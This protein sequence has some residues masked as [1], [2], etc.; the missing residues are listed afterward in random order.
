MET[1]IE[2]EVM[3]E[4]I[5]KYYQLS[6]AES[7]VVRGLVNE[8]LRGN[9]TVPLSEALETAAVVAQEL[10]REMRKAFYEFKLRETAHAVC[11]RGNL[12]ATEALP[13]TPSRHRDVGEL[14]VVRAHDI[15]HILFA[16]L[17][18]EAFAW[19]TIQ[20]GYV[21]NDVMPVEAH[22]HL[23]TSSG[24]ANTFDLH[25][26]DAFHPC[27]GDYLGLMCLRNP[28]AVPTILTCISVDEISEASC[29]ILFEPRFV[30]GAN[31]AQEVPQ[32]AHGS[33]VFWGNR[34]D[35]YFR[36]NLNASAAIGNDDSAA[37]ALKEMADCLRAN[38]TEVIFQPGDFWYIDNYRVAHGRGPF[39]PSFAGSD[40]W[41]RRLYITS[42]FRRSAT[43]RVAPAA[44]VLN[45]ITLR[46]NYL[47]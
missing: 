47:P 3:A 35:P 1:V 34:G 23:L 4:V 13:P 20:N 5:L 29:D 37:H 12:Y 18:G 24:S 22:R 44:R 15:M 9:D 16:S 10:P 46:P 43:Y 21:I 36:I 2:C 39:E 45:P 14:E 30:V 17:L 40:R 32:V 28:T 38:V 41:L 19:T 25:T 6:D 11:V 7:E 33:P 8:T 26:E 31:I 27:A 42:S